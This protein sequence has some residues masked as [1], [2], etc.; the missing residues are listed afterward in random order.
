LRHCK[1]GFLALAGLV[2]SGP[3]ASLSAAELEPGEFDPAPYEAMLQK[4]VKDGWVD[5][6]AWKAN[7]LPALDAFLAAAGGYDLTSIMGKE[8]RAAF[9]INAHNAW[10]VR[11]ILEQY[12]VDSVTEIPGF[13]RDNT[14]RIAGEEHSLK[15]LEAELAAMVPRYPTFAFAL[16]RGTVGGPKLRNVAV[17]GATFVPYVIDAAAAAIS[18][19]QQVRY[20]PETNA[21]HVPPQLLAHVQLYFAFTKGMGEVL[22]DYVP[23]DALVAIN[24]NKPVL[25]VDSQDLTLNDVSRRPAKP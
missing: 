21:L 4:Y 1:L 14:I 17:T 22:A 12:P 13:F 15:S 2:A 9:L 6:A 11:Q 3:A 24:Y 10:A 20:E 16:A 23:L 7:D 8:P 19:E 25:V 5:Y 18:R